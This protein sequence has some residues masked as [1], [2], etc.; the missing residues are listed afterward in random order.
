[1]RSDRYKEEPLTEKKKTKRGPLK[2]LLVFILLLAAAIAGT[3][4][5]FY[6]SAYES[7]DVDFTEKSP[8]LEFGEDHAAMSYVKASTGDVTADMVYIDTSVTGEGQITFTAEKPVLGGILTPSKEFV[9]KYSVVDSVPPLMIWG[10]DGTLLE[11]G[12]EFDINDVIA[13]GDN[14][15]PEP[16]V[17]VDGKVNMDKSG[18]Y[19][20]HVKVTDASG[21]NTEWDLTVSVADELPSYTDT[22][23]KTEFGDFV[24][25]YKADGRSF[26][27]DISAWQD[28]VDFKALKKAGCEFVIIRIGYTYDGEI[29]IDKDFK[30]NYEGARD[31]GLRTGVYLYSA[32]TTEEQVRASA[33]W[34]RETLG[35]DSLDLPVA[36][37]WE[38]FGNYQDYGISFYE[39]NRLYDA[40]AEELSKGGYGCML[41][42]SKNYL[43]KVWEKTDVR[44]VWLAHYTEKTDY[45]GP[46]MLWQASC[47]GKISG[48]K[49]DVDM[50]ILYNN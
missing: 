21:N 20:L 18:D 47:T 40:F 34:I 23:E 6:Y 22:T 25:A 30:N 45:E 39:L 36:F 10:G 9:L 17:S 48:I 13:Y 46:Y 37:D 15:D 29:N 14:A 11:R 33:E 1:M 12:T 4:A 35:G 3:T 16:Q 8:V 26:G 31:A 32:D 38:D 19:P 41:Y 50:D 28:E 2:A 7:L 24:K 42:G 43:E 44:P 49:G 5:W 27:L